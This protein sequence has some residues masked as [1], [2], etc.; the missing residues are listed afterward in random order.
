MID[1]YYRMSK[2]ET[3]LKTIEFV[4]DRIVDVIKSQLCVCIEIQRE[5]LVLREDSFKQ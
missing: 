4:I 5:F 1:Y 3:L 2:Q